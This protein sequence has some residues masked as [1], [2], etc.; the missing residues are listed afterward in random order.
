MSKRF[1]K[2]AESNGNEV[3][4]TKCSIVVL[5]NR[6][7]PSPSHHTSKLPVVVNVLQEYLQLMLIKISK[8]KTSVLLLQGIT[9]HEK[10]LQKKTDIYVCT[11]HG[12]AQNHRRFKS[13]LRTVW[14][15]FTNSSTLAHSSAL[16]SSGVLIV[17]SSGNRRYKQWAMR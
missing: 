15:T 2:K 10:Q 13:T 4:M 16:C 12:M 5:Q 7:H 8:V 17:S 11:T 3:F 6:S 1:G 14:N 9:I